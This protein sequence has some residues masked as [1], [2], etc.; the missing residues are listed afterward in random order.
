MPT[1][2]MLRHSREGALLSGKIKHWIV[3]ASGISRIAPVSAARD[4][5]LRPAAA[6]LSVVIPT[7]VQYCPG[8][9]RLVAVHVQHDRREPVHFLVVR[10]GK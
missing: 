10:H 4:S 2:P 5:I 3:K 8:K 1:P 7:Q 9:I 6:P